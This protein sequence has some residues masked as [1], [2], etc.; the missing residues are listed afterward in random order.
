MLNANRIFS[1]VLDPQK[2]RVILADYYRLCGRGVETGI[3]TPNT[4]KSLGLIEET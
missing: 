3:F 1:L 2:W 4:R